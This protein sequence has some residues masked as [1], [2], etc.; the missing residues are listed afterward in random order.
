MTLVCLACKIAI[1]SEAWPAPPCAE[2]GGDDWER[3]NPDPPRVA[4]LLTINDAKFLRG[5]R[6]ARD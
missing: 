4:Y 3:L 6:V 5:I 2:C 1:E